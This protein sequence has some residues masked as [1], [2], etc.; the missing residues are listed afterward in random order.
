MIPQIL[1]DL[2]ISSCVLIVG[3][4]GGFDIFA[5]LPLYF[6]LKA[7]GKDVVLANLSFTELDACEGSRPVPEILAVT[8]GTTGPSRYFPELHLVRWLEDHGYCHPLYAI[9]REGAAGVAAAYHWLQEAIK[10]DTIILVDGGTDILMRGDEAGLGTPQEDIASLAAANRLESVV[11]RYVMCLGFGVDTFHGVCHAHFLE[12]VAALTAIDGYLG[13]WSLLPRSPEF[14]FYEAACKYVHDRM[15][16]RKS[17][18]NSSIIASANGWFGDRHPTDRTTGSPLFLN[19][20]MSQYWAFDLAAVAGRNL[21]LDHI[22]D[23]A[24]YYDLS[25]AIETFR[26]KLPKQRVWRE[27]PF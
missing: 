25:L 3:A 16:W 22:R 26:A 4:G 18:V 17:I 9:R 13:S 27:I 15:P 5:G 14:Q 8:G 20:L 21:Y 1:T 7:K 6:W 24:S 10:P 2:E 23:T 12:N 11:R 19:P